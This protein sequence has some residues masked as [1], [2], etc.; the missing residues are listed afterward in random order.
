MAAIPLDLFDDNY[1]TYDM[2]ANNLLRVLRP[3]ASE[4]GVGFCA[5]AAAALWV[6]V[7]AASAAARE[8]C[9]A[10]VLLW[11][12]FFSGVPLCGLTPA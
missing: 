10:E 4:G 6:L 8:N 12:L 1:F 2:D 3:T 5:A 7:R 9:V 11:G